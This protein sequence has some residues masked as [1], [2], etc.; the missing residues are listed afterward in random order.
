MWARCSACDIVP[1]VKVIPLGT[2]SG[3]PTITRNVSALAVAWEGEWILCD[4]GE[5]TQIQIMRAGLHTS[6]LT[7]VF[8]THLH[9]DH[10]N[11]LAGLLSTMALD[12]RQKSLTLVGPPGLRDYLELLGRLKIL[13]TGYSI[14]VREFGPGGFKAGE[15]ATVFHN[16]DYRV[17]SLPLDHRI[18]ALGYR[19]QENPRPG[20]FD[21]ER[22]RRLGV[23]EGPLFGRLQSGHSVVLADGRMVAP[24]DVLGPERPGKAIAYCA[25]TRPCASVL[26]LAREVD[27]LIHE[28]TFTRDLAPQAREYG[29]STAAQAAEA[30]RKSGARRLLITHFSPRYPDLYPLLDEAKQ[31]FPRTLLAEELTEL[32]V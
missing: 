18:F 25:D 20:R 17:L 23:P 28:A 22:A 31:T 12:R 16:S 5:A 30:A 3:K 29:H 32:E 8:I 15:P 24:D 14:E 27:L 26:E 13:S 6:R 11:G 2:V 21:V 10:L 4:C 1:S 9:G 7:A 19:V